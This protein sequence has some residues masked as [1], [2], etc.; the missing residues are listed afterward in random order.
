MLDAQKL[1]DANATYRP[2]FQ[3]SLAGQSRT[4][5]LAQMVEST[6]AEEEYHFTDELGLPVEF[7][8]SGEMQELKA[9]AFQIKN[10]DW[11]NIVRVHK[12]EIQDDK[13]NIVL[14]RLDNAATTYPRH[15]RKIL[16]ELLLNGFT[17]NGYDGV[18]FI[19]A[20]H[21]TKDGTQSNYTNLAL[22]PTNFDLA[23]KAFLGRTDFHGEILDV[24]P[25]HLTVGPALRSTAQAIVKASLTTNGGTNTN[26]GYVELRVEPRITGN[27]WFLTD[28]SR[29]IK[30]FILQE[31][32]AP[33]VGDLKQ[34]KAG[35]PWYVIETDARYN[36]G[37]GLWHLIQGCQP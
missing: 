10:K 29:E 22:D 9:E 23:V 16:I 20:T 24:V 35:S 30:P 28:E 17:L 27:Q 19:G 26:F 7:T 21:P 1:A 33:Q 6:G 2:Y 5:E 25:T 37:F 15:M 8:G 36:V 31:R 12:N 11:S 4:L 3:E 32:Q 18:P 14:P 34:L 13:T